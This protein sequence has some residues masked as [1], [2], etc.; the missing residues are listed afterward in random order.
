[1]STAPFSGFPQDGL[2]DESDEATVVGPPSTSGVRPPGSILRGRYRLGVSIGRGGMGEVFEAEELSTGRLV[3]VKVVSRNFADE[4]LMAR[5]HREAEAARRVHSEF[6]PELYDIDSTADGELFLVMERL[7]GETLAQRLRARH[8]VLGWEDVRA[9]GEDMLR[10]LIDAHAAGI[11]H[12]DLKPGNIFLE[13][14]ADRP[15]GERAKILD[16]G[17]CKLDVHDGES[18]TSTGEAVGTISYMAPEQIRGASKVD[19]RADV[20]SFAMVAFEALSGRLAHDASG[21]IAMI[22]SKLERPARNLREVVRVAVPV[23]LDALLARCLSRR[24]DDRVATASDLLRSWR[25]LG[26]PTVEPLTGPVAER[27]ELHFSNETGVTAGA[28]TQPST[29]GTRIGLVVAASALAASSVVLIFAL[30]ARDTAPPPAQATAAPAT[31]EAPTVI[32]P[33]TATS[34]SVESLP[35]A[36]APPPPEPVSMDDEADAAPAKAA[37]PGAIRKRPPQK[38]VASP[39]PTST[40]PQITVEPRY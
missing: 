34:I 32:T 9:L 28:M 23:G 27:P 26:A 3:A 36:A 37:K 6:V 14:R 10:G 38:P 20:Y 24:P 8:G 5:L 18:L 12:R 30:R 19:E 1:M 29:R 22:A 13:R 4:L 2:T 39:R 11:V 40:T 21:Q 15:G 33:P 25:A 17:V 31:V 35:S 16:F 7:Y